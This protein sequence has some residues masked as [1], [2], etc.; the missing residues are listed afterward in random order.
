MFKCISS[1]PTC[2]RSGCNKDCFVTDACAHTYLQFYFPL[3]HQPLQQYLHCR[4][5]TQLL[6]KSVD[7]LRLYQ[8]SEI[9]CIL[10]LLHKYVSLS[11]PKY[12]VCESCPNFS[13]SKS[14]Q[15]LTSLQVTLL[16]ESIITIKIKLHIWGESR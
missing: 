1:S 9:A 13:F 4:G 2:F 3:S 12:I 8:M 15:F 11:V 10:K 7:P 16:Q 6:R 5:K 14:V